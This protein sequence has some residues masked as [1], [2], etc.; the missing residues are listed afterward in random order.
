[1]KSDKRLNAL[2]C[3]GASNYTDKPRAELDYYATEPKAV[4]C[5]LEVEQFKPFVWECACGEIQ[6]IGG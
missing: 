6:R 4:T 3:N 5:L 2:I 1:M